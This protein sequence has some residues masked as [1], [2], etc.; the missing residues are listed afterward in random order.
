MPKFS[1]EPSCVPKLLV[2]NIDRPFHYEIMTC[3][4]YLHNSK[5]HQIS[6]ANKWNAHWI[7]RAQFG[8]K[9]PFESDVLAMNLR[10]F[11]TIITLL[12]IK[13]WLALVLPGSSP[14]LFHLASQPPCSER[15]VIFRNMKYMTKIMVNW[16][17]GVYGIYGII[18]FICVF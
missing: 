10:H 17:Y 13:L 14:F 16:I 6:R 18:V 11:Y 4:G 8:Y 5:F 12:D 7:P 2:P 3:I 1:L 9:H 15:T